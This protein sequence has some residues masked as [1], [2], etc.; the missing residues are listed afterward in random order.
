MSSA[1]QRPTPTP[2]DDD[3]HGEGNYSAT[4]RHR[5][6]V[7]KFI[8]SGKVDEAAH[9]AAPASEKEAREMKEAEQAG[10]SH[11]RK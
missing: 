6:S 2:A 11:A 4:R 1:P 5:E 8:D 10:L 3:M 9:E 7:K